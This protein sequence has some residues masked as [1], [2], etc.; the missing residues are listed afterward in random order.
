MEVLKRWAVAGRVDSYSALSADLDAVEHPVCHHSST[1]SRL[2]EEVCR[3]EQRAGSPVMLSAIVVKAR[4]VP[5]EQFFV[6]AKQSPFHRQ[7]QADWTWEKERD[8]VFA[9]YRQAG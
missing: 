7:D 6:L 1:M 4:R 5:S 3:Q 2:L 9:H 8:R